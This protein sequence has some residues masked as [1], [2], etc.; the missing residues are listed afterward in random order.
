MHNFTSSLFHYTNQRATLVSILR[1]GLLPN[2]CKE[3]FNSENQT[4]TVIGIPMVSFCDIPIMRTHDFSARYGRFAIAFSKEWALKNHINPIL[5]IQNK[6]FDAAMNLFWQIEHQ[7]FQDSGANGDTLTLTIDPHISQSFPQLTNFIN[8]I[9][10][11]QANNTFLGFVKRYQMEHKG[12]MQNNYE[13][14]EWRYIVKEDKKGGIQWLRGNENYK[15]W[16]GDDK[17]PK[18]K[19]SEELIRQKLIFNVDDITYLITSSENDTHKLI[20]DISK[21][22][23]FCGGVLSESDRYLLVNKIISFEKIDKDF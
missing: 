11:R 21:M 15:Q 9:K 23:Q 19:P 17:T 6:D 10:T 14:N 16:R 1:K 2:Y 7:F 12:K 4:M 20:R 3:E 13:E 22:V 18:P 8:Y 5:Y